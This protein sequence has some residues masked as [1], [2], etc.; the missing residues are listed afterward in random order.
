MVR[1]RLLR[2]RCLVWL[3]VAWGLTLAPAPR[4]GAA[5]PLPPARGDGANGGLE[6]ARAELE[7]RLIQS[8]LAALGVSGAEAAEV[9]ARLTPD[10]RA[11]LVARADEL[12]AGG[13]VLVAVVALGVIVGMGVILV[14][15]LIRRPGI[16]PPPQPEG[17]KP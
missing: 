7:R 5:A 10:E 17:S 1:D 3:V 13:N 2:R 16:S 12:R 8:R 14:P 6:S 9:W 15:E 11:E 4:P